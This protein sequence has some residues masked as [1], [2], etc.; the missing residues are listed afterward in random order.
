[1]NFLIDSV[2][3][4]TNPL[5]TPKTPFPPPKP[6]QVCGGFGFSRMLGGGKSAGGFSRMLGGQAC[7][8]LAEGCFQI[9]PQKSGNAFEFRFS[10]GLHIDDLP[11]LEYIK[12]QL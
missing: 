11:V 5:P 6:P 9:T 8:G 12:S 4:Q 3:L 2:V 1:M 10:F 7:G